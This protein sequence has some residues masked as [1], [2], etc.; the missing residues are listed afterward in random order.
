MK[1]PT[2]EVKRLLRIVIEEFD[3]EDISIRERQILKWRKLKLLWENFT[4]V[5]Y[6]DVA[7]DW[8]IWDETSDQENAD[9]EY[10]DKSV[11]VF[12]AY[13][14]SI[15]AALSVTVPP[16][17][18]YPDD[19]NDTLDLATAKA[20]D[21]IAALIYR[22]NDAP[23]LWLHGLFVYVTEG[24]VAC[25]SYP[26]KSIEYG[27]YKVQKIENSAEEH[28]F[29]RC[30]E[31][32]YD[33]DDTPLTPEMIA[34]KDKLDLNKDK[35]QPDDSDVLLQ[36]TTEINEE[37]PNCLQL[38]AP[39]V[40]RETVI[41]ERIVGE[42]NEPKSRICLEAYGGL[43]IKVPNYARK[44]EDCPYLRYSYETNYVNAMEQFSHLQGKKDSIFKKLRE[45]TGPH[46]PYEQWA[47]VSPQ[48]N[49]DYPENVVTMNNWWFRPQAF[50]VLPEDED[51][52]KLKKLFPNG[53]HVTMVNDEFGS[54]VNESFDDNWT[55]TYNP[56]SDYIHSDPLGSLLVSIQ[57]ITNDLISL[58]LQTIE[59]G[60][61]Q[62]FADPAVLN[63]TAYGKMQSTPGAIYEATPKSGKSV[64]DAFYE[65]KTATLSQE[66][67][68]FSTQIQSLGQLTSGALP[69]LF[70]GQIES[71]S[72]TASEYSMSRAQS[73]QRLQGNWKI[74][75]AW[76]KQI[77]GKVIPMFIKET[78]DDEKDVQ[79]NKD[80]TF[81]NILIRRAEL[82]GKIGK[83]EL[84]ANEN[85]PMTWNQ[86]KDIIMQLLQSSNP[87]IVAMLAAPENL[88]YLR[89]AI[90]LNDM[91]IPGEDDKTLQND[92]IRLLLN[93][94]PIPNP[95]AQDPNIMIQAELTGQPPPEPELP[96]IEID[97]DFNMHPIHFEIIRKWA[98]SDEGQQAKVDNPN[99]HRNVLL[100]GKAHLMQIQM[101]AQMQA[102]QA[103]DNTPTKKPNEKNREAP[104]MEEGNV[105]TIQ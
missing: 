80:G 38:I 30:P 56:L 16:V 15:I 59:H 22:H 4:R 32:G 87:Q 44:Q 66:I 76:W 13:L 34:I 46:D 97:V 14:E 7:H 103:Q 19:A 99:G 91:F 48:Y 78:K 52:K 49:G 39:L 33:L 69:S 100:H 77:F 60:I 20:G 11:N 72:G 82:E 88:T 26:K 70:G 61:P 50:N 10:Y 47:R 79:K 55:I 64:S 6:S 86:Q 105:P 74:L 104:I 71:G 25:Y 81:V 43:N 84:E 65:V 41:I 98:V 54:A 27:T 67:M 36:G 40:V 68:P 57:E 2:E 18:C 28:E 1:E 101:A 62:T 90:G 21:K 73:L 24:M 96:S 23:L 102:M 8:R 42:T 9:Q 17:K 63:F 89:E 93:S 92:E 35:F 58:V 5:W 37:C 95:E 12:R 3:K 85:L 83:V 45:S 29:I 51:I 75:T 31:C 53:V 94:E